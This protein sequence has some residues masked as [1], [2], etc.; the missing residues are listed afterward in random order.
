MGSS[1]LDSPEPGGAGFRDFDELVRLLCE[2]PDAAKA[3]NKF[4]DAGP[5]LLEID[6]VITEPAGRQVAIY[7]LCDGLA[8]H[9][10]ALRA[11]KAIANKA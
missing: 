6:R 9:L 8:I 3:V 1:E 7:K 2:F 5:V 10:T 11:R 4:L